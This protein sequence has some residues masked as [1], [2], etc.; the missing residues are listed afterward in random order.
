[1]QPWN[2]EAEESKE[3][4]LNSAVMVPRN[5]SLPSL[6]ELNEGDQDKDRRLTELEAAYSSAKVS[7]G[8]KDNYIAELKVQLEYFR[9]KFDEVNEIKSRYGSVDIQAAAQVQNDDNQ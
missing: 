4:S 5:T 8:E 6:A 9:K 2:Q 1:M 7:I 3:P